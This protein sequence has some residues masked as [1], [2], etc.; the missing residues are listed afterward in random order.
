MP[1]GPAITPATMRATIDGTRR[2]APEHQDD[3]S[4]RVHEDELVQHAVRRHTSTLQEAI[5]GWP[6]SRPQSSVMDHRAS[7]CLARFSSC[8]PQYIFIFPAALAFSSLK[9]ATVT[10]VLSPLSTK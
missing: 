3:D 5:S 4:E 6:S 8:C 2:R 7:T 9:C 1:A 10:A